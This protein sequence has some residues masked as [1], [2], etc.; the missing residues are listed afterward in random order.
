MLGAL[1]T[2]GKMPGPCPQTNA[3]N[4]TH[5]SSVHGV[6][7]QRRKKPGKGLQE[8]GATRNDDGRIDLGWGKKLE[9]VLLVGNHNNKGQKEEIRV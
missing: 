9:T 2:P 8:E 3:E 4:R 1:R 6:K 5:Q 7:G